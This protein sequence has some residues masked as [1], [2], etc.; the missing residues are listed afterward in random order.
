MTVA[1]QRNGKGGAIR[2]RPQDRD[3]DLVSHYQASAVACWACACAMCWANR[4]S[5]LTGARFS[6]G[7]ETLAHH[8][9]H[10][11]AGIREQDV[12]AE[13]SQAV[14]QLRLRQVT[15]GEDTSLLYFAQEGGFGFQFASYGQGQD[16]LVHV[17]SQDVGLGIHIQL[18]V[19]LPLFLEDVRGIRRFERDILGVNTLDVEFRL[20]FLVVD[21]VS[22][23]V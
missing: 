12:R 19:R 23:F 21:L 4:A 13:G 17:L 1:R 6:C 7:K 18:D 11:F 5:K 10:G 20:Y 15:D 9:G 8:V 14:S 2:P 22:H 3:S 16:N